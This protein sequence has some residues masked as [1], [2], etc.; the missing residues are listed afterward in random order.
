MVGVG[1]MLVVM[2]EEI[3]NGGEVGGHGGGDGGWKGWPKG[4]ARLRFGC[5]CW[6]EMK[7]ERKNERERERGGCVY[8]EK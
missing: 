4:E 5:C 7:K 8:R 1:V 2:E 3:M 6:L